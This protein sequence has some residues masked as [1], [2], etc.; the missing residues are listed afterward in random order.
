MRT[1]FLKLVKE[2]IYSPNFYRSVLGRPLSFSLKYF[3]TLVLGFSIVLTFYFSFLLVP[4]F[5]AI[6][7]SVG[8]AILKIVI[9][10]P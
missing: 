5:N 8:P 9:V 3:Y 1:K 4:R 7:S 2:S 6:L 10:L